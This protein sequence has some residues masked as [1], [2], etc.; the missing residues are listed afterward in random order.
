MSVR[1][2]RRDAP[3]S[4]RD[5]QG[6]QQVQSLDCSGPNNSRRQG[7]FGA[8]LA[9]SPCHRTSITSYET[10]EQSIRAPCLWARS[11]D[12]QI[13]TWSLETKSRNTLSSFTISYCTRTYPRLS[14]T[15]TRDTDMHGSRGR[16]GLT[17]TANTVW[18]QSRTSE[19]L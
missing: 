1:L 4:Y 9:A 15:S 18:L 7:S 13:C 6:S 11:S 3:Y 17:V 19:L 16:L 10:A 14:I 12:P 2:A 8:M 5:R